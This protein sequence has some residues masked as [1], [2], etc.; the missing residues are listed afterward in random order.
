MLNKQVATGL[1]VSAALAGLVIVHLFGKVLGNLGIVSD[2]LLILGAI[3]GYKLATDSLSREELAD[4]F[5]DAVNLDDLASSLVDG[6]KS[7]YNTVLGIDEVEELEDFI[8]SIGLTEDSE[9]EV[10]TIPRK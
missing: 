5:M 2:A 7:I 10:E 9:D 8:F 3:Q 6:G 1:K 4:E